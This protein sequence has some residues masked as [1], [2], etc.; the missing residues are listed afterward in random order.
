MKIGN[1]LL[2]LKNIYPWESKQKHR[3]E[4]K[5][6]MRFGLESEAFA[7]VNISLIDKAGWLSWTSLKLSLPWPTTRHNCAITVQNDQGIDKQIFRGTSCDNDEPILNVSRIN[8]TNGLKVLTQL[9]KKPSDVF[10]CNESSENYKQ[11]EKSRS[12][13]ARAC[14]SVSLCNQLVARS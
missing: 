1:F 4:R 14:E 11:R 3:R 8:C 7:L 6:L 5:K 13:L 9:Q 12:Q 2:T 10:K